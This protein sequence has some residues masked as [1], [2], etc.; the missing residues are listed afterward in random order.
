MMLRTFNV[1]LGCIWLSLGV[2]SMAVEPQPE[3]WIESNH[4]HAPWNNLTLWCRSPSQVSSKFLL[5]KDN[6]HMTWTRSSYKTFQVSFFIGALCESTTGV[7]QCYYWKE[8]GWSKPS[9]VLELQ[10]PGQL[11]KPIFWIQ[12]KTPPLPGCNANILCD[13]WI[14][15]LVFVL[16][17]EGNTEPVDYQ[18]PTGTMSIFSIDKLAPEKEGIYLC[19]THYQMLPT[20]W[21]E[22]SNPLKLVV[23]GGCGH[24]CW[25]LTIIIPG[26]MAG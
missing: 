18:V 10:S 26:I 16:F 22:P 8:K 15:D 25:H 7:Y 20:L 19:R 9:N 17:K 3:L 4:P 23:A 1:L 6:T 24:G 13:G 2:A 12:A 14:Q 21:S 5:M 11:P